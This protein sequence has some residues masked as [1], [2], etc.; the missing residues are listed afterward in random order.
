MTQTQI[1][2]LAPPLVMPLDLECLDTT[3]LCYHVQY[4][5]IPVIFHR[6]SRKKCNIMHACIKLHYTGMREL[7]PFPP[8]CHPFLGLE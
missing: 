3:V 7:P 1:D 6:E 4:W 2:P 8:A 5:Q